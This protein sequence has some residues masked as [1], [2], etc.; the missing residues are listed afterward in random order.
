M[1][2]SSSIEPTISNM[3]KESMTPLRR[4]SKLSGTSTGSNPIPLIT[5]EYRVSR[6]CRIFSGLMSLIRVQN[7]SGLCDPGGNNALEADQPKR[8]QRSGQAS[9][10]SDDPDS[11]AVHAT[12]E[13][14]TPIGFAWSTV[15]SRFW[16]LAARPK[17]SPSDT[18]RLG[19]LRN[20][21]VGR[22]HRCQSSLRTFL[23]V[24]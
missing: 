5:S 6:N 9:A 19:F 24:L 1:W 22:F 21:E 3:P 10:Q 23:L 16:K 15:L 7:G 4:K 13:M 18:E 14:V 2:N 12:I 8:R 17:R 11:A 20:F